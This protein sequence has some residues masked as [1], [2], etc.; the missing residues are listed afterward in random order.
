MFPDDALHLEHGAEGGATP[1]LS[2]YRVHPC[3][4]RTFCLKRRVYVIPG[5]EFATA[6]TGPHSCAGRTR[7]APECDSYTGGYGLD[8]E[9]L[10]RP[11]SNEGRKSC[12][13]GVVG[14]W[15]SMCDDG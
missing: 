5:C 14:V 1:I 10:M 4:K 9:V 6:S 13:L 15:H 3:T 2:S 11:P 8:Q 12:S 7:V